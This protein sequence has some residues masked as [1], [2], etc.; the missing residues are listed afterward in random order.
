MPIASCQF[1]RILHSAA[2]ALLV[3]VMGLGVGQGR[4]RADKLLDETTDFTGTF[5]YLELKV[6]GL[7]IGVIRNGETSVRGFG[8]IADGSDKEPDGDTLMRIG[9]ITKV[10]CGATLASMVADGTVSFTDQAAG[11][12]RL[13]REDPGARRQAD[14]ADRPRHARLRP[15][16]RGGRKAGRGRHRGTKQ[17]G[18][19]HL[20][21]R[22]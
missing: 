1:R 7:V 10:F 17:G 13:G 18:L 2:L 15:A 8:K 22:A 20:L 12:A 11:P 21:D 6:P 16:A 4:A 14:Q 3:V 19:C 9:S 5:I